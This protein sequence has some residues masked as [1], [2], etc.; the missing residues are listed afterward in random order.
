MKLQTKLQVYTSVFM[1]VLILLINTAIY[2][3]FYQISANT[4]LEWLEG[5]TND[6]TTALNENQ[7]VPT[8]DLIKAYLPSHGMIQVIAK[9]GSI[10]NQST[11]DVAYTK[12]KKQ[13]SNKEMQTIVTGKEIDIAVITKPIIWRNGEVVTLQVSQHLIALKENMTVLFYVLTVASL[14]ILIPTILAARILSRFLLKPIK[15]LIQAMKEN[16]ENKK[17][18]KIKQKNR[19]GDE[20]HEMEQTFNEMIDKLEENFRKQETFVSDASHELKTPIS[21]VKSYA[22]LLK[23]RGMERPE[24]FNEAIEAIDSEADRMQKLVEQMLVLARSE[25]TID[26]E[27]VNMAQL[28]QEAVRT[29][30]GAYK[31]KID[32]R[33]Q[34]TKA[35]VYGNK[36]QLQQVVY[37]LVDNALKYSEDEVV[38]SLTEEAAFVVL[39]VTDSGQGIPEHEQQRI[40]DRFYRVDKARSRITGGTGLGLPIAKTIVETHQGMLSVASK[41]GEG[42]TFKLRLP[43]EM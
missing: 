16:K 10:I 14:L 3:L 17:W 19:S 32:F 13:F 4:E 29:F 25:G 11:K 31:R 6:L 20:L 26:K 35:I 23:R 15:E 24:L 7:H 9:D 39:T 5:N 21:I 2:A 33:V 40:F 1:L 12:L 30:G 42:S 28:C 18:R 37:I 8:K 38:L 43:K 41:V 22:Q 34:T 36:S 27:Q